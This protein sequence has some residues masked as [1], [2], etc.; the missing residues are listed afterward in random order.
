MKNKK[1]WQDL[2]EKTTAF[3]IA[4]VGVIVRTGNAAAF[5][6][7]VKVVEELEGEKVVGAHLEHINAIR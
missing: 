5:V 7:G 2:G 4:G 6:P 3:D 1:L